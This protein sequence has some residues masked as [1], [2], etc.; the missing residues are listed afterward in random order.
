MNCHNKLTNDILC[1]YAFS[2]SVSSFF[3]V[4]VYFWHCMSVLIIYTVILVWTLSFLVLSCLVFVFVAILRLAGFVLLLKIAIWVDPMKSVYFPVLK[5]L[6]YAPP[7]IHTQQLVRGAPCG[8]SVQPC[9]TLL[10]SW[11]PAKGGGSLSPFSVPDGFIKRLPMVPSGPLIS[12]RQQ[13]SASRLCSLK[14]Q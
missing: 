14:W 12:G 1:N 3:F 2:I 13:R 7:H 9:L 10:L 8:A 4:L 11:L 6:K 5:S